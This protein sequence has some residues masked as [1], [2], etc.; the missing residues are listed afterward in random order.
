MLA[1]FVG[2]RQLRPETTIEELGLS[3]LER[4][5]LMVALEERA[6]T[7]IDEGRFAEARSVG[8]LQALVAAGPA[9]TES[10]SETAAEWVMP[11]W[12]RGRLVSRFPAGGPLS[13]SC[14]R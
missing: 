1:R 12:N 11:A 14:F 4:V 13:A 5:E 7:R 10:G 8:D 6:Q 2:D 9:A 3:S